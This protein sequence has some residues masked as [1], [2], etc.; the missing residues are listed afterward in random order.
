MFFGK[1]S[2]NNNGV[3]VNTSLFTSY[4]DTCKLTMGAWNLQLSLKFHPFKGVNG[5]GIRQYA[6]DNTEIINTSLTVENTTALLEA[7]EKDFLP[8]IEKGEECSVSVLI[9]TGENR[10]L[11]SIETDGTDIYAVIYIN[12][13][14]DGTVPNPDTNTLKHKFNKKDYMVGYNCTTGS[15]E[16]KSVNAEYENFVKKLN[17]IY[18][19]APVTAHAINYNNALKASYSNRSAA[20]APVNS[21]PQYTAPTT[22]YNDSDM[23]DFLPFS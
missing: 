22:N 4:S 16:Q 15:G 13:Q 7:I 11:L 9:S 8:A 17:S 1:P 10:K 14:D 5:E 20:N 18:D 6:Q 19:L 23:S 12:V 3:N 21:A 2:N